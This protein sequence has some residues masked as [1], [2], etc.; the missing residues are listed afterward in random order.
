MVGPHV[1]ADDDLF[2]G[3]LFHVGYVFVVIITDETA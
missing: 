1:N 3:F 2:P